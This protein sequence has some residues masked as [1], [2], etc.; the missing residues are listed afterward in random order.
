M[1][2]LKKIRFYAKRLTGSYTRSC[3]I[4]FRLN[5]TAK[6]LLVKLAAQRGMSVGEYLARLVCDHLLQ[7]EQANA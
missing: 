7:V 6:D 2:P 5:E 4:G 3:Q 1:S